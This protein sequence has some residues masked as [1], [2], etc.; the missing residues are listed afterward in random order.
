MDNKDKIISIRD[1]K[2]EFQIKQS[3]LH[4]LFAKKQK[5]VKAVDGISLD[6][7]QGEIVSLVGESGSGKTTL[8]KAILNLAPVTAG[9]VQFKGKV[10]KH[11]DKKELKL[12]RQKAQMIFQDPY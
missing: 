1:L 8:G 4:E 7:H 5:I 6:I 10:V 3:F 9:E 12:F 11:T 2:V